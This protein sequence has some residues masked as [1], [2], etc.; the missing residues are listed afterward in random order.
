MFLYNSCRKIAWACWVIAD[1]FSVDRRPGPI[2]WN[3]NALSTNSHHS[4][5]TR[6]AAEKP[7]I[8]LWFPFYPFTCVSLP[9]THFLLLPAHTQPLSSAA[10]PF[11]VLTFSSTSHPL[12]NPPSPMN[13]FSLPSLIPFSLPPWSAVVFSSRMYLEDSFYWISRINEVTQY[14]TGLL[15]LPQQVSR[16][17]GVGEKKEKKNQKEPDAQGIDYSCMIL[18]IN[19]VFG[20]FL[21]HIE[22][23]GA[24]L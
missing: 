21:K 15:L 7:L 2:H 22:M 10:G 19:K 24:N 13:I 18:G 3:S 17:E 8:N 14:R 9:H 6:I 4:V 23:L 20:K 5:C 11:A 1:M 16:L 12:L